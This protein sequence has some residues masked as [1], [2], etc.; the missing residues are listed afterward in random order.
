MSFNVVC[1]RFNNLL[2]VYKNN[3]VELE[4]VFFNT[5]RKVKKIHVISTDGVFV[6]DSFGKHSIDNFINYWMHSEINLMVLTDKER[7]IL[8]KLFLNA[9]VAVH[10]FESNF[11]V[12]DHIKYTGNLESTYDFLQDKLSAVRGYGVT[13]L[14]LADDFQRKLLSKIKNKIKFKTN[15]DRAF[16]HAYLPPYQE[17]F[18]FAELRENRKV[19]ALDY[20]SMFSYCLEGDFVEP[21]ALQVLVLNKLYSGEKLMYGLY[22]VTLVNPNCSFIQKYHPFK[23]CSKGV[24]VHFN[25]SSEMCIDV[26]LFSFEIEYY[27]KFFR[28]VILN[29]AMVSNRTVG[30]PFYSESK[31]LFRLRRR[32]K[33]SGNRILERLYKHQLAMLH[34]CTN[35]RRF[36][37]KEISSSLDA[38]NLLNKEFFL[39]ENCDCSYVDNYFAGHGFIK[40]Y[41]REGRLLSSYLDM[42]SSSCVFSFSAQVLAR[43]RMEIVKTM[44]SLLNFSGLDICYVNTDSIHISIPAQIYSEFI[45]KFGNLIGLE[46]GQMKVQ[47]VAEKGVWFDLGHYYF[48]E[49]NKVKLFK[50]SFLRNKGSNDAFAYKRRV[51]IKCKHLKATVVGERSISFPNIISSKK[52]LAT[53]P[54]GFV[55]DFHRFNIEDISEYRK[56][57]VK[58]ISE[59]F[60]S[61]NFKIRY[62][63]ALKEMSCNNNKNPCM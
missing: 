32:A 19:I 1:S 58:I 14:S 45:N 46:L 53:S 63:N 33:S 36:K 39:E 38:A 47:E 51:L 35:P 17:V 43:S 13:G 61:L 4:R 50:N 31:R 8:V 59:R 44:E 16:A 6:F 20:N 26:Q 23:F 55:V 24:S 41:E 25:A 22:K 10:S 15:L 57:K 40:F 52:M 12:F 11:P 3:Q 7:D 34:S 60:R 56:L 21:S 9:T 42:D 62:F 48:L 28:E 49:N 54:N 2:P 37:T 27:V 5:N 18:R 29:E 30:H